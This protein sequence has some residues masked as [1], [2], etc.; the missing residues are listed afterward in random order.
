MNNHRTGIYPYHIHHDLRQSDHFYNKNYT[1]F[2]EHDFQSLV[3]R[4]S[5]EEPEAFYLTE[6]D[7]KY[8]STQELETIENIKK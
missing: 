3:L 7:Q 6:D 2:H 1:A 4:V 8:Y 5:S